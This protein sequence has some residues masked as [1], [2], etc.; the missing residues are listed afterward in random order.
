MRIRE[1]FYL[2]KSDRIAIVFLFAL[3]AVA[4]TAMLVIGNTKDEDIESAVSAIVS[5][6]RDGVSPFGEKRYGMTERKAE[7]FAFDPNTADS[8]VFLRL[9]LQPWMIR[10]IYK[11]RAAGGIF[12]SRG[13][14][15]R[16]YGITK[17][18][19]EKLAPYIRIA[20]DYLPASEFYSSYYDNNQSATREN[21]QPAAPR[22]TSLYPHK[23]KTGEHIAL[24]T[25]D[26]TQ[27]K[28]IPGIGSSFARAIL[29]RREKLGGFYS[30]SQLLEIDGFPQEAIAYVHV[31]ASAVRRLN[32]NK[33]TYSQLRQHP[34]FNF[35]Q[36]RDIVDYRRLRGNIKSLADLR[37]MK[38][39][40][41]ADIERL[42]HYVEF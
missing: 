7:L 33:L 13:D 25:A 16:V 15:A 32:I 34:Y 40:T 4:F 26:T 1:L 35:Y 9:G 6:G 30:S 42:K 24:N 27:L 28:K 31:D 41:A 29:R 10:N 8:T 17:K 19:Y 39:F 2:H 18:Q 14:F 3:A 38:S 37:L 20:D 12:R 36:A 23:L 21:R 22:D 5:N 11:Y